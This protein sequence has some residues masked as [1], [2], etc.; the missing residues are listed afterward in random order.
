MDRQMNGQTEMA[1]SM[2]PAK[3]GVGDKNNFKI[4]GWLPLL[5]NH[6]EYHVTDR[7]FLRLYINLTP[8]LSNSGS[9]LE[10][11]DL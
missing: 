6:D 3:V 11:I 10:E 4:S 7:T 5:Q 8:E 2:S 1:I 9:F